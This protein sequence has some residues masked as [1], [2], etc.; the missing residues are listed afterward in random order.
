MMK[1]LYT[2][3]LLLGWTLISAQ[4]REFK[5]HL[6]DVISKNQLNKTFTFHTSEDKAMR[7]T[8]KLT[9][10]GRTP[11]AYKVVY[12]SETY[13]AAASRHGY[14][15]LVV[16]DGKGKQYYY[17][18][19]SKPFKMKNGVLYFR[20]VG[21]NGNVYYFKQDLTKGL[22]MFLCVDANDCFNYRTE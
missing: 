1:F 3:V 4:S 15:M 21:K 19:V 17:W 10:F 18:D 14:E 22:P 13:P 20:H 5:K 8:S 12:V 7:T 2:A 9:Y 16:I 11:N 6:A